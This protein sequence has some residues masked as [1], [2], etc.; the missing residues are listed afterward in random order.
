MELLHIAQNTSLKIMKPSESQ[1]MGNTSVGNSLGGV[2]NNMNNNILQ[3]SFGGNNSL[4]NP[5]KAS[6]NNV[7]R[8]FI[9]W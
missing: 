1:W 5:S 6:E 4:L 2:I 7:I 3:G 8:T 9:L